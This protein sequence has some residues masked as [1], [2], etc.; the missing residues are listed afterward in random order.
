M[1]TRML[2]FLCDERGATAVEYA[3]LGSVI[4]LLI[5]NAV[6][7]IGVRLSSEFSEV[8]TIYK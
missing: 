5:V 8:S 3:L 6:T 1:R 2:K 4:V 7:A